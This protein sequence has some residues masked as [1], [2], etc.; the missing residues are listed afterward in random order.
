MKPDEIETKIAIAAAGIDRFFDDGFT[1][2]PEEKFRVLFAG[3]ALEE[4]LIQKALLTWEARGAMARRSRV[5][6]F[7]EVLHPISDTKP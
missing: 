1:K 5:D 3:A 7:V 6:C 2:W 4:D